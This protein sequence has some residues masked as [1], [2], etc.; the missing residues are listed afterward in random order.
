E[1][2]SGKAGTAIVPPGSTRPPLPGRAVPAVV[3][4]PTPALP[5][6]VP[7]ITSHAVL[8]ALRA[9]GGVTSP[10]VLREALA[11]TTPARRR[12]VL[13]T[14]FTLEQSGRVTRSPGGSVQ[15]P[16][17]AFM[18]PAARAVTPARAGVPTSRQAAAD[19]PVDVPAFADVQDAQRWALQNIRGLHQVDYSE[20][21]LD[22]AQVM[23]RVVKQI[24]D[25]F[26]V[27]VP[28]IMPNTWPGWGM[29]PSNA[30]MFAGR[31]GIGYNPNHWQ[32]HTRDLFLAVEELALHT[33][34]A[35]KG[36]E[37]IVAHEMAHV[38][39]Q[40]GRGLTYQ[41]SERLA[42]EIVDR[43]RARRG[44]TAIRRELGDY[45]WEGSKQ[46]QDEPWRETWAQAFSAYWVN[47]AS[48]SNETRAM[49]REVLK[50]LFP[51]AKR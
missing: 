21:D 28:V 20:M 40:N 45:A 2:V 8:R 31:I 48:V 12:E 18:L 26:E 22:V 51:G 32:E 44:E 19:A 50:A 39:Q 43:Y 47:P 27:P 49:V 9:R 37:A 10:A 35:G 33:S 24:S 17:A 41:R 13:R 38:L 7:D 14:L 30:P 11:A 3:P 29:S 1:V 4:R 5:A 34:V 46:Q 36:V 25:Q 16:G 23:N 6:E 15:L 42:Q